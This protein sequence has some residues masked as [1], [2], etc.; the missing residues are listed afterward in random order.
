[1]YEYCR[2]TPCFSTLLVIDSYN[3]FLRGEI[4]ISNVGHIKNTDTRGSGVQLLKIAMIAVVFLVGL[5]ALLGLVN[6]QLPSGSVAK[7]AIDVENNSISLALSQEPPQMNSMRTTDAVS[8]MLLGHV[9][10]GLIRHGPNNQLIPGVAKSWELH[11]LGGTFHLRH[12]AYWSNGTR[13]TA[14]DFVFAWQ[15]ALKPATASPYSFILYPLKNAQEINEGKAEAETLGAVAVDDF[16]LEISLARPAPHLLALLAFFTYL[17]VNQEFYDSTA[18]NYGSDADLMIYNGPFKITSWLHARSLRLEKN[19]HYWAA[20][21]TKLDAIDFAHITSDPNANINLF[22]T[23][24]IALTGLDLQNIQRALN[25]RWPIKDHVDGSVWYLTFNLRP[26]RVTSNRNLRKAIQMATDPHELVYKVYRTPGNIPGASIFPVWL[27]GVN[28]MFRDEFPAPLHTPDIELAKEYLALAKSELGVEKIP[29]LVLLTSNTPTADKQAQY[30]QNLFKRQLDIVIKIDKQIFKQRLA[31]SE[32][33][34]FDIVAGG[35]GPDYD[36]VLTFGDLFASWNDNN[37]GLFHN[38]ELDEAVLV[39]ENSL[40]QQER[41]EAMDIVQ[42][43]LYEEAPIIV[44]ME[45]GSVYVIDERLKGVSRRSVGIDPDYTR[46]YIADD[47]LEG[48]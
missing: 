42:R 47:S 10:E 36:D 45:R 31:K 28:G 39:A 34:D 11:E 37:R 2:R 48:E 1:M 32:A 3:S 21:R 19:E 35:W 6:S 7:H 16:T 33:G 13:V 18:G 5:V 20:E 27:K 46:A 25:N 23:G 26:E 41:M 44:E 15:T 29:P 9:K 12:D 38:E 22:A 43:V 17:P 14:H 24:K 30:Y 8:G 40:D 4:I